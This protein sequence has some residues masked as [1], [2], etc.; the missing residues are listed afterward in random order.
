MHCWWIKLRLS[1]MHFKGIK[2]SFLCISFSISIR[3]IDFLFEIKN[4]M[5]SSQYQ[6]RYV[7]VSNTSD[8]NDCCIYI[9]WTD[10]MTAMLRTGVYICF[11]SHVEFWHVD[12]STLKQVVTAV[13]TR[14][15]YYFYITTTCTNARTACQYITRTKID[16]YQACDVSKPNVLFPTLLQL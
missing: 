7:L 1:N 16:L 5:F 15:P 9:I 3:K 8:G 13:Y 2:S 4:T 12:S 10:C 6:M 14:Q 11:G